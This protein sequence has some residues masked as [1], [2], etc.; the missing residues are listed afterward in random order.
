MLQSNHVGGIDVAT[1]GRARGQMCGKQ[2]YVCVPDAWLVDAWG[3][4]DATL[5][6][7]AIVD[8]CLVG[9]DSKSPGPDL[10]R[11]YGENTAHNIPIHKLHIYAPK[12]QFYM[13]LSECVFMRMSHL[14]PRSIYMYNL[15]Y[16]Y[17]TITH[18]PY[19]LRV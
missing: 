5:G 4:M 12:L 16:I 7:V 14:D 15:F 13:V 17:G 19:S 9:I 6:Y 11:L 8:I 2:C 10:L 1:V 3:N 18:F